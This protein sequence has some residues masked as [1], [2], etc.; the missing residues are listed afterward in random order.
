MKSVLYARVSSE[1]QDVDLSISGQIKALLVYAVQNKYEVVREFVDEAE[2]GKTSD[3]PQFLEMISFAKQK[4]KPFDVVLVWKFSR[5]ARNREDSIFFKSKLRKLGVVVKSINEPVDDTP[6]GQM[7]EGFLETMDEYY[8]ANLSREVTRGMRESASRGFFVGCNA[9]DGFNKVK[10]DEGGRER[11]K[12]AINHNRAPIIER[13]FNESDSGKGLTELTK[14]LNKEGVL[15]P[16]GGAWTKTTI[17]GILTNEAYTGTLIWDKRNRKGR[18]PIRVEN[19][20]PA[21]VS[22]ELFERVNAKLKQRAFMFLHPRRVASAYLLSGIAKCG[23]CG[24]ALVGVDAKHG[25]F[26]YYACGTILK[27]G[28]G[29]CK[30][31]YQN[32]D[33]LETAT[34]DEI[35][36]V[37][38]EEGQLN[39]LV[40]L[41]NEENDASNHE[42]KSKLI[43]INAN[44]IDIDKK[45]ERLINAVENGKV[46]L[47]DL[48]PRIKQHKEQRQLL[49]KNRW[50]VEWQLKNRRVELADTKTVRR[51]L[52]ELREVLAEGSLDEK[53]TVV[54][55]FIKEIKVKGGS[56]NMTYRMPL[57]AKGSNEELATVPRIVQH[58]G[59]Y[60]I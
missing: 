36:R 7:F 53:K 3:R 16:N 42:L 21:I 45:L 29:S 38:L 49:E 6:E 2:S 4:P 15:A 47:N 5:F 30:A 35:C 8:S 9:P 27:Q 37:I 24:K 41:Y 39:E 59:R 13:L 54:K 32:R 20:W 12:L 60:R 28:S 23:Y 58:G 43:G 46:D 26:S 48:A 52:S 1:K 11:Y 10:V 44:I 51:C 55:G 50:E 17:Y 40:R 33:K 18:E 56:V 19:A 22:K 57:P 31:K 25:R 34:I 14:E